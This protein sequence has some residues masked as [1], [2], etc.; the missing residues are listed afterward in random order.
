VP[1]RSALL[2]ASATMNPPPDHQ[3]PRRSL[4]GAAVIPPKATDNPFKATCRHGAKRSTSLHGLNS[5]VQ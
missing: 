1:F 5:S 2:F 4:A 3:L